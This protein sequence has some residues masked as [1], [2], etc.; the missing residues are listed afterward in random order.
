MQNQSTT[1]DSFECV[2]GYGQ[3]FSILIKS[4]DQFQDEMVREMILK[5][6]GFIKFFIRYLFA[7]FF[8]NL[9]NLETFQIW[10]EKKLV[11]G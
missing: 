7:S 3:N 2:W 9:E 8:Y 5:A 4:Q 6:T 11:F 1:Q 10:H